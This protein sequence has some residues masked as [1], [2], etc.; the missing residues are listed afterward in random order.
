MNNVTPLQS[1]RE[2]SRSEW[3]AICARHLRGRCPSVDVRALDTAARSA[4]YDFY[5]RLGPE[6]A[7]CE[8]DLHHHPS[9]AS[10]ADRS[11]AL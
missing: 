10:Q 2:L 7:A 1:A 4:W 8:I 6:Q 3:I 5:P 9:P 11:S